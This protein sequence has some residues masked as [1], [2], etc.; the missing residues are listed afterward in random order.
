MR[1][2]TNKRTIV[3]NGGIGFFGTLT[4]ILIV[5]KLLKLIDLSW[6]WVLAPLWIP[7][8]IVIAGIAIYLLVLGIMIIIAKITHRKKSKELKRWR[9]TMFED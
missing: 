3:Y 6:I 5:L 2:E 8:A 7:T 9:K 1:T 4:L